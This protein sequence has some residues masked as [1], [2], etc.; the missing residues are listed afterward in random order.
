MRYHRKVRPISRANVR[1]LPGAQRALLPL[2]GP[3]QLPVA[4]LCQIAEGFPLG[5]RTVAVSDDR[6]TGTP[7]SVRVMATAD[8][9]IWLLAWAPGS[10]LGH[11]DHADATSV[12]RMVSGSL[13]ES[14]GT[15][16]RSVRPGMFSVTPARTGHRVWNAATTEATSLHVYSPPLVALSFRDAR[17]RRALHP[18]GGR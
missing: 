5:E 18:A 3:V 13:I 10:M 4:A 9:D 12:F 8:Y 2:T 15:I 17:P 7:V 11:H 1:R 6:R 14:V 16:N